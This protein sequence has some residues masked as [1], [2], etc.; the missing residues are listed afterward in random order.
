MAGGLRVDTAGLHAMAERW[1]GVTDDLA[2][3]VA[4]AGLGLSCQSS[5]AAVDAAHSEVAT[6]I[7]GLTSRVGGHA[8]R[9]V[10]DNTSYLAQDAASTDA[11]TG[12]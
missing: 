1:G 6:V 12:L 11:M 7:A 2:G 3:T 8:A 4:P 9:V 5:A 10:D